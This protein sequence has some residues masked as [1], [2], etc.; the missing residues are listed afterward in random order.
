MFQLK[1]ELIL[2]KIIGFDYHLITVDEKTQ[3]DYEQ[4]N[5]P[6]PFVKNKIK[7]IPHIIEV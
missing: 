4:I 2:L 3:Y 7:L 5:L 1:F 6:N